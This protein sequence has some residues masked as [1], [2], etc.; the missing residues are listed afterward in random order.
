MSNTSTPST[1]YLVTGGDYSDYHVVA[2]FADKADAQA[3]VEANGGDEILEEPLQ[4]ALPETYMMY[5]MSCDVPDDEPG[6][7]YRMVKTCWVDRS[8]AYRLWKLD[9]TELA[10]A[11]LD[12]LSGKPY[13][14]SRSGYRGRWRIQVT[15]TDQERVR[16]VYG[17]AKARIRAEIEGIT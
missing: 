10:P 9:D 5:E 1:V 14:P 7:L 3:F 13:A 15:G 8:L 11:T 6:D 16:K 4:S 2:V 17:D 12:P